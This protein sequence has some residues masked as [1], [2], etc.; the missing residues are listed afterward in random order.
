MEKDYRVLLQLYCNKL[1]Y[2]SLKLSKE[3]QSMG[4]PLE[5]SDIQSWIWD[6][7]IHHGEA[8]N[9]V[10]E[11]INAQHI[12]IHR[13]GYI[14]NGVIYK[15]DGSL[16]KPGVDLKSASTKDIKEYLDKTGFSVKERI[17]YYKEMVQ[18]KSLSASQRMKALDTVN[19]LAGD[20]QTKK[21]VNAKP[22]KGGSGGKSPDSKKNKVEGQGTL[23]SGSYKMLD[24][25]FAS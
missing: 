3:L 17:D 2:S 10:L 9:E 14:K 23:L 21:S 18:D 19:I 4:I 13:D 1:G 20:I 25:A 15:E 24:K 12:L 11:I 22:T 16:L 6:M 7:E 8:F 5:E